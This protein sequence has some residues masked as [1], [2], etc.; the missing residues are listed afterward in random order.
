VTGSRGPTGARGPTGVQGPT[1]ARG[2]TGPTGTAGTVAANVAASEST[3]SPV[4]TDLATLGPTVTVV[5][6]ASGRVLV[7][8]TTS[9][10]GNAGSTACFMSFAG[11]GANTITAVDANAVIQ[12]GGA[13]QRASASSVLTGLNPGSTTLTAKYRITGGGAASCSFA[14]RSIFSIPLP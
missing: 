13:I 3:S 8:V 11:S 4:Y 2:P 10:L 1:G 12:L 7:T 9:E 6:P 5:V 14:N